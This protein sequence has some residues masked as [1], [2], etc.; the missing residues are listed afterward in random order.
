MLIAG[1]AAMLLPLAAAEHFLVP[2][3]SSQYLQMKSVNY[4]I[5][6]SGG[7][8]VLLLGDSTVRNLHGRIEDIDRDD[9][10]ANLGA[11]GAMSRE[12]FYS[13]RNAARRTK[14]FKAVVVG[15]SNGQAVE[16]VDSFPPYYPFLLDL[17]DAWDEYRAGNLDGPKAARLAL[18]EKSKLIYAKE[19]ILYGIVSNLFPQ[20]RQFMMDQVVSQKLRDGKVFSPPT[21]P[22]NFTSRFEGLQRLVDE[23]RKNNLKI[24]FVLSPTTTAIRESPHYRGNK[25]LFHEACHTLQLG[26]ADFSDKIPDRCFSEDGVHLQ[27]KYA[28]LYKELIENLLKKERVL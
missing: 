8:R 2:V 10:V 28:A 5:E 9:E 18:Y 14:D 19:D 3:F 16:S 20:T 15:M 22:P 13:L 26:C 1:A 25:N 11:G 7:G 4:A 12:W 6:H 17:R 21:E 27:E 23:A 24:F